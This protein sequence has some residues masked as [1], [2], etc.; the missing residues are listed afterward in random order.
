MAVGF[1]GLQGQSVSYCMGGTSYFSIDLFAGIPFIICCVRTGIFPSVWSKDQVSLIPRPGEL[2]DPGN[3]HP[4][5]QTSVFSKLF[6]K[7][8]Y[9]RLSD[10]MDRNHI[11]SKYPYGFRLDRS[12]HIF[13]FFLKSFIYTGT[14]HSAMPIFSI[15]QFTMVTLF[16]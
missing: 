5:T 13:F 15:I 3:G 1:L 8:I 14:I 12:T 4:I 2:T 7:I 11:F 16:S 6:E 9:Y 10:H